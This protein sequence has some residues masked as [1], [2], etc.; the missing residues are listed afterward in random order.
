[1]K[2]I[3]ALSVVAM[4]LAPA[5]AGV[6]DQNQDDNS[7]FMASFAQGD[8]AQS[9]QQFNDTITGAGIF[10]QSDV[11]TSDMVTIT[12][13]DALPNAGGSALASGSANG[14]AGSWVDVSWSSVSIAADTTYFLVF[15]SA[16]DTLGVA[17]SV[18][19][20]YDRGQVYANTG[21]Q[22][23]P[24]FDYAFR[25]YAVP[26]PASAALLGMGGLLISRRRR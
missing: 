25:T 20:P 14:T 4:A 24:D 6:I 17:G 2:T 10:L 26:T 3:A 11:G 19:N 18:N 13:W 9:F 12:L 21:F 23:F 5:A 8:L 15:T 22:S 1:M 16:N 7:I